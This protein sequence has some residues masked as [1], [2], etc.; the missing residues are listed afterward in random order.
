MGMQLENA[1]DWLSEFTIEVTSGS[2]GA[3]NKG[4]QQIM[5][6][7]TAE[8]IADETVTLEEFASLLPEVREAMEHPKFLDTLNE[9]KPW[10]WNTE[11][12]P[13]F[14]FL[15]GQIAALSSN[16]LSKVF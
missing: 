11:H 6:T 3:Y 7:L 2:E 9:T 12:D 16:P 4:N 14:D 10:S 13:S 1:T 15:S 8:P 5:I